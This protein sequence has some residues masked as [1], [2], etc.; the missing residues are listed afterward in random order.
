MKARTPVARRAFTLV[1]IVVVLTILAVLSAMTVPAL[2]GLEKERAARAPID[3]LE[4][5]VRTVR[6]KAMAEQMPYQ[7]GF[8]SRGFHAARYYNPYGEAEEFDQ[9]ATEAAAMEQRQE[10]IDASRNR[11]G[12][13]GEETPEQKAERERIEGLRAGAAYI[14]TYELPDGLRC[15]VRTL[16]DTDW[17]D[18]KSGLFKR[19]VFQPSGMCAPMKVRI[20]NDTAYFEVDFHPLTG[21]IRREKSWVE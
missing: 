3:A 12:D 1:E 11:Y 15:E 21:Q 8:D 19:W 20:Q 16:G 13:L 17:V 6:G 5:L 7:I 9:I 2:I 4:R 10:I 14:E 18:V